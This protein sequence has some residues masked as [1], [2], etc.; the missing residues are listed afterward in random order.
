VK[1]ARSTTNLAGKARSTAG[2]SD[3]MAD[4]SVVPVTYAVCLAF[5]A[6][7]I[8]SEF[9]ELGKM[10]GSVNRAYSETASANANDRAAA[11]RKLL[12][13]ERRERFART[14]HTD[15]AADSQTASAAP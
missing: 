14:A 12:F 6:L 2:Q 9:G 7:L 13:D 8:V 5:V 4:R 10:A 15:L 3:E 1:A 11:D